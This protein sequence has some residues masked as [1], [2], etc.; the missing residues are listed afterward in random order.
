MDVRWVRELNFIHE[1]ELLEERDRV[2]HP[3]ATPLIG[4]EKC[5]ASV[6]MAVPLGYSVGFSEPH[7][8]KM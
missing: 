8:R 3:T 2:D 6:S 1:V 5:A 7:I 4:T